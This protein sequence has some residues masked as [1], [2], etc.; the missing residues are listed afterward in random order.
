MSRENWRRIAK[1]EE[2][3]TATA[4]AYVWRAFGQTVDEAIAARFPYGVPVDYRLVVLQW[5]DGGAYGRTT[6]RAVSEWPP[7]R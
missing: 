5:Q 7:C 4:R 1:L 2:R 3:T 6:R